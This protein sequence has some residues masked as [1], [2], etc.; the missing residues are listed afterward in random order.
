MATSALRCLTLW[1]DYL[2]LHFDEPGH[3]GFGVVIA[4]VAIEGDAT[5]RNLGLVSLRMII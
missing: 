4:T 1:Q 3:E 5:V 2:P